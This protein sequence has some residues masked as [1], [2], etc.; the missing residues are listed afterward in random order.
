MKLQLMRLLI[1][2]ILPDCI[3]SSDEHQKGRTDN[4]TKSNPSEL[5]I[6]Q[7]QYESYMKHETRRIVNNSSDIH[8]IANHET[9]SDG[10]KKGSYSGDKFVFEEEYVPTN[11]FNDERKTI[12][13]IKKELRE[14][15]DIEV[16]CIPIIDGEAD[17][18]S[19]AVVHIPYSK[20]LEKRT[21]T[22]L[23]SMEY[24][25]ESKRLDGVDTTE[26]RLSSLRDVFGKTD[27]GKDKRSKNFSAAD[28]ITVE[29]QADIP[30]LDKPYT[31]KDLRRWRRDNH[32]SWDE[33]L[34][35]GYILVPSVIHSEI[36][37]R[38]L[39][40]YVTSAVKAYAEEKEY[41]RTHSESLYWEEED[42]PISISGLLDKGKK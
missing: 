19:I 22:D 16:G 38:G 28:Q 32:F 2:A 13:E 24:E 35:N 27:T 37:H 1:K 4:A 23:E 29:M 8:K 34:D 42:A 12:G 20:V 11:R 14:K 41:R 15:Y 30:G 5:E 17:I 6:S 26:E 3:I 39:V 9:T 31:V 40:G 21:G 7:E 36:K 33:Q 10:R 25:L 18:S